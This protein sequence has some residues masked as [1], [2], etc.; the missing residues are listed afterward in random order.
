MTT[1]AIR[2][3]QRIGLLPDPPAQPRAT[4]P[5]R[6]PTPTASCLQ[7]RPTVRAEARCIAARRLLQYQVDAGLHNERRPG[8]P[9]SG[10]SAARGNYKHRAR[11]AL[12]G[13]VSDRCQ[14][15]LRPDRRS[16]AGNI[17]HRRVRGRI[18]VDVAHF[19]I[20]RRVPARPSTP[21]MPA[22]DRITT[23]DWKLYSMGQLRYQPA[24]M[25]ADQLE[26][27]LATAYR[28]FHSSSGPLALPPSLPG[29]QDCL[30]HGP[31]HCQLQRRPPL[32][33]HACVA[34][35]GL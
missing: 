6:R 19:F 12:D 31:E 27:G 22:E 30:P 8:L 17:E 16:V 24:N 28:D 26:T 2:F 33:E 21:R 5:M 11:Y 13:F 32:Q 20:S 23:F 9:G 35:A 3:Y 14:R 1:E 10:T 18:G 25:T 7:D 15:R 4:A 29:P 34:R